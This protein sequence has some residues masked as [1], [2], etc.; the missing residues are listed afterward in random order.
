MYI[1]EPSEKAQ[2]V[3]IWLHGLGSN[4]QDMASLSSVL[5]VK[6]SVQHI[7]LQAPSIAVTINGG[8]IMPAWYDINLPGVN[9]REDLNG[10][11]DSQSYLESII[12][13]QISAGFNSQQI[14]LAGFSQ[15]GAVALFT[16]I[17]YAKPLGGVICLSGYLPCQQHITT[18]QAINMPIFCGIGSNDDVVLPKWTKAG[19]QFLVQQQ[20][21]EVMVRE[22][23]M[24]HSVCPEEIKD[25]SKWIAECIETNKIRHQMAGGVQL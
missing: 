11:I 6:E 23:N 7:H 22:Y 9:T 1:K 8:M 17:N 14:F 21:N 2:A 5:T 25:V 16:G 3:I 15:G 18:K 20:Y 13:Q 12:E 10:L 24:A 19:L 4:A